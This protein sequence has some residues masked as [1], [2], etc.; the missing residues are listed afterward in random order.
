MR[1]LPLRRVLCPIDFSRFTPGCLR[2]ASAIARAHKADLRA[3]HVLPSEGPAAPASL[4]F[5]DREA[6][7]SRLRAS[8]AKAAPS[9]DLVG[10]AVDRAPRSS[11]LRA[12]D[13]PTNLCRA[14]RPSPTCTCL[15]PWRT[16]VAG[17]M[18]GHHRNVEA[19]AGGSGVFSRSCAP[20]ISRPRRG[21]HRQ[22]C[23]GW[24][25]RPDYV[26][27]IGVGAGWRRTRDA[28]FGDSPR[29]PMV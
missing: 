12:H 22:R 4:D 7:M 9:Y 10:A 17:R 15:G 20:S 3:L 1:R 23:R 5:E 28:C 24:G 25:G 21:A 18:S 8:L 27:V 29:Q 26:C 16:C 14:G 19:R 11:P 2:V 6:L 13:R